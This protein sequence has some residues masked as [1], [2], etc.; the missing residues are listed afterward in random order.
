MVCNIW[1][2]ALEF[3][4]VRLPLGYGQERS[5]LQHLE[6][7]T[8]VWVGKTAPLLMSR[9]EVVCNIWS[10][11]LEF[12]W[13]RLPLANGQERSAFQHLE[14]CTG[15]SVSKTTPLQMVRRELV[16]YI[17]SHALEFRWARLPLCYGQERSGMQHLESCTGVWV[18][19]TA[20]LLMSRRE[21]V[22]NIWSHALEFCSETLPPC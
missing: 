20:P 10:H 16:C 22:C 14:S 21:V 7:C 5:G 2:H 3:G 9:I 1:S 17:W 6:S 18:N 13:V 8:G 12:G 15:D 11:A 4:C 19:K